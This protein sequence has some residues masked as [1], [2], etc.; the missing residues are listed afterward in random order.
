MVKGD[1]FPPKPFMWRPATHPAGWMAAVRD[2]MAGHMSTVQ[3]IAALFVPMQLLQAALFAHYWRTQRERW[4]LLMGITFLLTAV[5]QLFVIFMVVPPVGLGQQVVPANMAALGLGLVTLTWALADWLDLPVAARP[6]VVLAM[7]AVAVALVV[8]RLTAGLTRLHAYETFQATLCAWAAMTTW[9]SLRRRRGAPLLTLVLLLDVGSIELVLSG[10]ARPELLN[11]SIP[12]VLALIGITMLA[13]GLTAARER[14]AQEAAARGEAERELRRLYGSLEQR[15]AE[16]TEALSTLVDALRGF[17]RTVSHDLRN[18]LVGIALAA[19]AA[20][21]RISAGDGPAAAE[22]IRG[23]RDEAQ[24][25][26]R[27]VRSLLEFAEAGEVALHR[28]R[29]ATGDMLR[30]IIDSLRSVMGATATRFVVD[31]VPDMEGDPVLLRQAFANII[32]NAIKYS[33][34]AGQP[35]VEIGGFDTPAG[36]GIYVR[37]NGPGFPDGEAERLFV[38]F[39]RL[40]PDDGDGAGVGRT[41]ARRAGLPGAFSITGRNFGRFAIFPSS[42]SK[43][44]TPVA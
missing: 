25:A 24:A 33:R 17:S 12:A 13:G 36:V 18:P 6:W 19:R 9:G 40:V 23:V 42:L 15:V 16:R 20:Q 5:P 8:A 27:M 39:V 21:E 22:I 30:E 43:D 26:D 41:S 44:E 35:R 32:G 14:V 34:S 29:I 10:H 4:A 7:A 38:P 31:P 2:T 1:Q 11:G 37:D 28:E 3:F